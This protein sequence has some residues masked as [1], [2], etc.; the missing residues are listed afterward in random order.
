[1]T[2]LCGLSQIKMIFAIDFF[3]HWWWDVALATIPCT[4]YTWQCHVFLLIWVAAIIGVEN[5][6]PGKLAEIGHVREYS[7]N[8]WCL[9]GP[10]VPKHLWRRQSTRGYTECYMWVFWAWAEILHHLVD[11]PIAI[12]LI[13]G[14]FIVPNSYQLLIRI[15]QPST[16]FHPMKSHPSSHSSC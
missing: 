15:S 9:N 5:W 12:P 4:P 13:Y 1:M 2:F 14:V 7:C 10:Y 11:G 16:V 8:K 6:I 3:C